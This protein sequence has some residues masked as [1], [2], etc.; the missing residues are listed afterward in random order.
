MDRERKRERERERKVIYRCR[1]FLANTP[2]IGDIEHQS[3][4]IKSI[5]GE[6]KKKKRRKWR[7]ITI[8]SKAREGRGT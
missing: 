1:T 5:G 2:H 6:K 7:M 4:R 3:S 8:G